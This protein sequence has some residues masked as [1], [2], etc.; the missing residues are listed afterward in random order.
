MASLKTHLPP[1][2]SNRVPNRSNYIL[3]DC[4]ADGANN[5]PDLPPRPPEAPP[6]LPAA[7]PETLAKVV[8]NF[9]EEEDGEDYWKEYDITV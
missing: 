5:T 2:P 7:P 3:V 9:G 4:V 8:E 6:K 1:A